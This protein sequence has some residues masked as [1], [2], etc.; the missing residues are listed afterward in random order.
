[1]SGLVEGTVTAG[2]AGWA[3]TAAPHAR[4]AVFA[5]PEVTVRQLGAAVQPW[6]AAITNPSHP[7]PAADDVARAILA[8]NGGDL[9]VDSLVTSSAAVSPARFPGGQVGQAV[10]LPIESDP[11]AAVP[12]FV[13]DLTVWAT[14]AATDR[15]AHDALLDYLPEPLAIPD[16][17]ADAATAVS[18]L[19]TVT[20]P[21]DLC[22]GNKFLRTVFDDTTSKQP[23]VATSM[24]RP[25]LTAMGTYFAATRIVP[26]Q[27]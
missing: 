14:L 18:L 12:Q 27:K 19:G 24:P 23:P 16:P 8:Y 9:G 22:A 11:T 2:A 3:Q 10:P 1:V 4:V 17:R 21:S 7:V 6:L 13:T 25:Q 26:N 20:Q 5:G 15:T